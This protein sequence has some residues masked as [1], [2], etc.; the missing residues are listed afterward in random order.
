VSGPGRVAVGVDLVEVAQVAQSVERFGAR[1]LRRVFTDHELACCDEGAATASLA[2]RFAAKEAA[3]K[4]LEPDG[5]Q[6][7]WRSIE[8]VQTPAGACRL[9]LRGEAARLASARGLR[10]L[11]VSLT[12]EAGMA[13]AVVVG[14]RRDED[15][16]DDIS[17]GAI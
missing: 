13:A 1:Y 17:E 7:D 14:D 4:V 5:G 15:A 2:A 10:Q 16:I 6:L 3:I 9:V 8:V 12:H 11:A